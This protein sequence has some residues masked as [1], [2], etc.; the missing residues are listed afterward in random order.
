MSRHASMS[1]LVRLENVT[2]SFGTNHTATTAVRDVS[3]EASCGELLLFLGPSGSGKTT[4]LTL[5]AGL[6]R[7]TSGT[8]HIFGRP[9]D[10]FSPAELQRLRATS[11]GFV[12]QN[13]LLL[14]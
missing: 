10:A 12:F 5:I 14:D 3:L 6:V 11:V 8:V 9:L 4:L 13:F 2:K 7:P 1:E